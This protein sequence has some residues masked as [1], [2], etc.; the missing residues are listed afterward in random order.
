MTISKLKL[1]LA[2]GLTLLMLLTPPAFA[3]PV[4]HYALS[5]VGAVKFGH[6]F[7]HFD[8][9]NPDAP[10]G[11]LVRQPVHLQGTTSLWSRP[12]P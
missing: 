5:R 11:G 10:K 8:W 12:G 1:P 9:V 3:E 6:D 4:R 2:A 7:K